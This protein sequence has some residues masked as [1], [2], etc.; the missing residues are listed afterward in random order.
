MKMKVESL[1]EECIKRLKQARV[2]QSDLD[3]GL[4]ERLLE[5]KAVMNDLRRF[6]MTREHTLEE[7]L[8]SIFEECIENSDINIKN[9]E[10]EL[11]KY[12]SALAAIN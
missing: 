9:L 11:V 12:D 7:E 2:V 1:K 4:E 8:K 10:K 3:K 6:I 5:V